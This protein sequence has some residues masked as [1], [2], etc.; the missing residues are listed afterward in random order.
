MHALIIAGGEGQRLRP[1]TDDRPKGMVAIAGKP[2]LQHQIEWLRDNGV[3]HAV[4]A[5]GYRHEA[6]L[7]HFGDGSEFGMSIDYSIEET[8]LGRGGALK[9]AYRHVPPD[10]LFV[11]ATNGDNLNSQPLGPMVRQHKRTKAVATLLLTQLRSPYG[12]ARQHGKRITGFTEKP[13]LPHWLNAGVYVLNREFLEA[14]PEVGDHEDRLF[15]ELSAAGKLYAFRSKS[16]WRAIDTVKDLREAEKE[17][18]A[19]ARK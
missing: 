18:L 1:L 2:I 6:I 8:P 5:C 10:E 15:P 16:Y 14:C 12:I 4:M 9:Q 19:S 3:V 11:I 7:E 13:L 17:L